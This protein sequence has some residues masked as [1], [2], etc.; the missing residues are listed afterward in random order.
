M[1]VCCT[2]HSR[3]RQV[4][5]LGKF[6]GYHKGSLPGLISLAKQVHD[7]VNLK[8]NKWRKAPRLKSASVLDQLLLTGG[9]MD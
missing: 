3:Q 8:F 2:D 6:L 5:H 7:Q 4:N 1:L 9:E